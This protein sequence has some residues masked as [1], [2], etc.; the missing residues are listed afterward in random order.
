MMTEKGI[1]KKFLSMPWADW[2]GKIIPK[3]MS[4]SGRELSDVCSV[5]GTY[6]CRKVTLRVVL[7]NWM[8]CDHIKDQRIKGM[9]AI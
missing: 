5:K 2:K 4:N 3:I 6:N 7:Q 8:V 1:L 9:Y